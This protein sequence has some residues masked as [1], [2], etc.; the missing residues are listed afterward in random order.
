MR[1]TPEQLGHPIS[2]RDAKAQMKAKNV[3]AKKEFKAS[4]NKAWNK[5]FAREEAANSRFDKSLTES[6]KNYKHRRDSL[7]EAAEDAEFNRK[8][9]SKDMVDELRYATERDRAQTA[10]RVNDWLSYGT[11]QSLE[12]KE[13]ERDS[14]ISEAASK[15][16]AKISRAKGAYKKARTMNK[17]DY[18]VVANK[19]RAKF[20][21]SKAVKQE[22]S[23][24]LVED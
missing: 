1:R 10:G 12:A 15:R 22:L 23:R 11:K 7:N 19:G 13:D 8:Y 2:K 24:R 17:A 9:R 21:D 3:L 5:Y 4:K 16:D 20:Y 6:E 18:R 14:A